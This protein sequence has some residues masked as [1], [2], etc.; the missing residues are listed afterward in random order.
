MKQALSSAPVLLTFDP[1]RRAVLTTDVSNLAVAPILTKPDDEGRQY[2]VASE[3]RKLTAAER[4]ELLA[5][6]HA[7]QV[8]RYCL[9]GAPRPAGRGPGS[10]VGEPRPAGSL[11]FRPADRQPGD[12]VAQDEP[13]PEQDVR[14]L[15]R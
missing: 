12:H 2:P 9:F 4:N 10:S 7:L 3:S 14:L 13:A 6:V 11:G 8:F 5:V 1:A 15:A